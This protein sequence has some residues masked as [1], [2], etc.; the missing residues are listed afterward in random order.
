MVIGELN[1]W[2]AHFG[3]F[4]ETCETHSLSPFVLELN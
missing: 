1:D 4:L 3:H 2:G